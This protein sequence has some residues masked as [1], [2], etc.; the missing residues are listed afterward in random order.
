MHL[1]TIFQEGASPTRAEL[2]DGVHVVGSGERCRIRLPDRA[3]SE[4]HAVL[5]LSGGRAFVED[6][7]SDTGTFVNA[8]PVGRR[9]EVLP[10]TPVTSVG[11]R[12]PSTSR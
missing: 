12:P 6:M 2:P 4:R 5:T 3:V 10:S 8:L 9:T 11:I 7:G 1:L